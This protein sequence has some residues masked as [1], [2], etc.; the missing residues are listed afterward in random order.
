VRALPLN[1]MRLP[2]LIDPST[3]L[4]THLRT[5]AD[6]RFNNFSHHDPPKHT[7]AATL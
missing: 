7:N 1:E 5:A 2:F 3:I 4:L 6:E